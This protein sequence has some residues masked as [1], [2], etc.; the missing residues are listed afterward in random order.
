MPGEYDIRDPRLFGLAKYLVQNGH[1]VRTDGSAALPFEDEAP[2]ADTPIEP[3]RLRPQDN[4]DPVFTTNI[5]ID[6]HGNPVKGE[7]RPLTDKDLHPEPTTLTT[8][9]GGEVLVVPAEQVEAFP[10]GYHYD[11]DGNIVPDKTEYDV[12]QWDDDS[13]PEDKPKGKGRK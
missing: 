8:A 5:R 12:I 2:G 4:G 3:A 6:E 9:P 7:K 1:A 11:E 10:D 13:V